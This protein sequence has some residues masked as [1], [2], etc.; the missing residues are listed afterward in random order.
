[1]G[2]FLA[3]A[4]TFSMDNQE[5]WLLLKTRMIIIIYLD[6][7]IEQITSGF[8][9]CKIDLRGQCPLNNWKAALNGFA[10]IFS[11]RVHL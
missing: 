7:Q 4:K 1:M 10:I 5:L 8:T 2:M 11:D 3:I 6:Y 9:D